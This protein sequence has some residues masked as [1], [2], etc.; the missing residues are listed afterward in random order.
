[1]CWA[2]SAS[3]AYA[4]PPRYGEAS[5]SGARASPQGAQ[6]PAHNAREPGPEDAP[7]PSAYPAATG[8]LE[9]SRL[10]GSWVSHPDGNPMGNI[11][12]GFVFWY[13]GADIP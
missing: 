12:Q 1:M 2:A 10:E 3:G 13:H 11:S 4:A 5:S 6:G 7:P 9:L 8:G